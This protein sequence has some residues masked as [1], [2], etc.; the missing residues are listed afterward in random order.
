MVGIKWETTLNKI[1]R[2]IAPY[3]SF[4]R[5][6]SIIIVNDPSTNAFATEGGLVLVTVG[7]LA[8]IQTMDELRLILGHEIGHV[9]Y[10]HPYLSYIEERKLQNKQN[11][12][13][14]LGYALGGIVG[15]LVSYSLQSAAIMNKNKH[16][17]IQE[18][19]ADEFAGNF[20]L[21][22]NYSVSEGARIYQVFYRDLEKITYK[23]GRNPTQ[24]IY[25]STHPE[26]LD[27]YNS[28]ID[29]YGKVSEDNQQELSEDFI[30]MRHKARLRKLD[31]L[32]AKKAYREVIDIG[33]HYLLKDNDNVEI[34]ERMLV[35]LDGIRD[36]R[37]ANY[38]L[39]R[40]L[41]NGYKI[42][43]E[44]EKQIAEA[45]MSSDEAKE[46]VRAILRMT[47]NK[48]GTP[49]PLNITFSQLSDSI[50]KRSGPYRPI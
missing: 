15:V 14:V 11:A 1:V 26:P 10:H 50:S 25:G 18:T 12:S 29:T 22:E 2:D 30:A 39:G 27:R 9:H 47:D 46:L 43:D 13:M 48:G 4:N 7:M 24:G 34:R 16:S 35:A 8:D 44:L 38:I 36:E 45:D 31:I 42:D 5:E 21:E 3:S 28:I 40:V 33:W 19:E 17:R 37:T 32:N 6:Y 49:F 20:M 23:T 41:S